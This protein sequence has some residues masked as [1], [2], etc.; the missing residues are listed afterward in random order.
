MHR[1]GVVRHQ[2]IAQAQE[3]DH[4]RQRRFPCEIQTTLRR[5]AEDFLAQR[6]IVLATEDGEARVRHRGGGLLHE[7][8]EVRHRPAFVHPTRARLQ[9]DPT[10]ASEIPFRFHAGRHGGSFWQPVEIMFH[11]HAER[12]QHGEIPIHGVR[13]IGRAADDDVVETVRAFARFVETGEKFPV[14]EPRE[15]AGAREALQIDDEIELVRAE[16][17]DGAQHFRPVAWFA[18]APAFKVDESGQVRIA[19]QQRRE[20]GINPPEDLR[21]RMVTLQQ[22]QHRHGVDDI[23]KRTGFEDEYFQSG[24]STSTS[25]ARRMRDSCQPR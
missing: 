21:V 25:F 16:P 9:G 3:F 18:P 6:R 13:V 5:S 11:F 17:R 20:T 23:A 2:Q 15:D 7:L 4:L 24:I 19:F 14:G 8:C 1:P 12:R 10:R 22:T